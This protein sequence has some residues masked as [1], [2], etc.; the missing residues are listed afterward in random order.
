[1]YTLHPKELHYIAR[2]SGA[3]AL[4]T[5]SAVRSNVEK[6]LEG[7]PERLQLI[8]VDQPSDDRAKNF[9]D[10]LVPCKD[11]EDDGIAEETAVI[12]YTSGTTGDPKGVLL[13]HKNLYSNA[14]N[15]AKHNETERGTAQHWVFCR[16]PMCMG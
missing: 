12:L 10:V 7:M 6:S 15:S 8:V 5:S 11:Q 1:M 16:L 13:T 9:Y 4:I 14:E 3:K 2:N